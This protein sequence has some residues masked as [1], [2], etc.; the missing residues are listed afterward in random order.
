MESNTF[1]NLDTRLTY[2]EISVKLEYIV[3]IAF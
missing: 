1:Q 3:K 2:Y